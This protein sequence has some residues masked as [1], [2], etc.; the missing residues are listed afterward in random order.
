M[1]IPNQSSLKT[2]IVMLFRR[3]VAMDAYLIQTALKQKGDLYTIQ[4]IYKE[5][6][7]LSQEGI[8]QKLSLIHI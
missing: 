8:V 1:P 7:H 5:L 6:R 3:E 4:A 2:K